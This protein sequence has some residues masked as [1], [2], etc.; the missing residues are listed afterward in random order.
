MNIRLLSA[1]DELRYNKPMNILRGTGRLVLSLAVA[2]MLTAWI[3]AGVLQATVFNREAVQGW[4]RESGAYGSVVNSFVQLR[5]DQPHPLL[6]L[7]NIKTALNETFPATYVQQQSEKAINATYDWIEGKEP[8][9]AFIIP[10]NEKQETF[11]A[12][13]IKQVEA[14]LATLPPCPT[15]VNPNPENPTCIPQGMNA[16]DFA[17]RLTP[18]LITEGGKF[19]DKPITPQLVGQNIDLGKGSSAWLPQAYST[20]KLLTIILPIGILLAAAAY[21]F[22]SEPRLKGLSTISRRIALNGLLLLAGGVIMAQ[23]GSNYDFNGLLQDSDMGA[24]INPLFH[25]VVPSI[26][27]TLA[28]MGGAV[29]AVGGISWVVALYLRRRQQPSTPRFEKQHEIHDLPAPPTPGKQL[30]DKPTAS[31]KLP[32]TAPPRPPSV[33]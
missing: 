13:M 26:G 24:I 22:L 17:A 2:M 20:T 28:A 30:N 4:L 1:P 9:I 29:M 10:V 6:Q 11:K 15:R 14:K 12:N 32:P 7:Q 18:D 33:V 27:R 16:A 25:Q 23:L 8:T 21:V 5:D 31:G 3:G 19:L